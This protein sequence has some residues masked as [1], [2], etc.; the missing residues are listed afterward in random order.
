MAV[1]P[2]VELYDNMK[3]GF[4]DVLKDVNAII[5]DGHVE[6]RPSYKVDVEV[7]LGGDYKV[8]FNWVVISLL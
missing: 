5:K 6:I 2:G 1:M 7:F 4:G 8:R 3:I